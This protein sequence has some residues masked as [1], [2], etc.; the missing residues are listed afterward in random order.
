MSGLN[1]QKFPM[2]RLPSPNALY[3]HRASRF[4]HLS[5]NQTFLADYL[6]LMAELAEIQ[7]RLMQSQSDN[8][9]DRSGAKT[10]ARS[11][12]LPPLDS[13]SHQ[14]S[15]A[16]RENL[17]NIAATITP[18]TGPLD[19][20]FDQI[21]K[22]ADSE[23]EA[24]AAWLLAGEWE[25]L[26]PGIAPFVAAALQVYWVSLA[27]NLDSDAVNQLEGRHPSGQQEEARYLC[28]V[29]GSLPV[30]GVLQTGGSVQG[31]R[32]LCCSLCATEWNLPRIHCVHC[33][34]SKGIA[35]FNIEGAG[36]AVL[37]EACAECGTYIKL[38]N[39]EKDAGLDPFADD[40]ASLALDI[41]MAEEGYQRLG[42]NPLL[43]PGNPP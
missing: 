34:S 20:I 7:H 25:T 8:H 6:S 3:Q 36:E 5:K 35:Y 21:R 17:H 38:M 4:R 2:L 39:R 32:Y 41:L 9:A 23:M 16:W 31:L 37:A 18:N 14:R 40:L 42:F 10:S 33:G 15:P 30:A 29:C 26:D 22:A 28:P 12:C 27:A 24:W 11:T 13:A 43:V 19:G 1:T